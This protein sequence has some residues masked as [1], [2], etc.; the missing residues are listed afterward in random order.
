MSIKS[1]LY[2]VLLS[3]MFSACTPTNDEL[4]DKAFTLSKEKKY[5]EAIKIYTDIISRN[6][7]LQL[8]YYNRGID[9]LSKK[10][11]KEALADFNKVMS[12][13]T[14]GDFHIWFNENT[15]VAGDVERTQV[16]YNDAL[17]QRAIVKFYMDS[18]RSSFIDFQTLVN[19]NYDQTS[20]C[21]LWQGTLWVKL[22]KLEKACE[23]FQ[24]AKQFANTSNDKQE[25]D[26][27]IKTYCSNIDKSKRK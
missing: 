19:D 26:E 27:M 13:Q 22:G 17:Y 2:F 9:Y 14:L 3:S 1:Y 23:Y 15:P 10:S 5:D 21:I 4:F 20:N 16:P 7:Q 24:K 6:D 12:L 18:S 8:A 25:A 11:Y